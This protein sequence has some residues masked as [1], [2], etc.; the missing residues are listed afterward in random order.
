VATEHPG[1]HTKA[2]RSDWDRDERD[3]LAGLEAQVD[4][5]HRRHGGS[6]PLEMLRAA[7]A[8]LLPSRLQTKLSQHLAESAVSRTLADGLGPDEPNLGAEERDRLLGRILAEARQAGARRRWVWPGSLLVVSAA[9][10]AASIAWL[11][12]DPARWEEPN[13]AP[14]AVARAQPPS[15]PPFL[16]SFDKPDV[17][18]DIASLTWRGASNG[19]LLTDLKPGLDAYRRGDYGTAERALTP[20]AAHHPES[21]E[22]FFYQGVSRLF[23]DDLPGA[24]EA[25]TTADAIADSGFASEVSWYLAVAEQRAGRTGEA[26]AR[27]EGLCTRS[28]TDAARACAAIEA[29]TTAATPP[30]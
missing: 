27:L 5:M 28:G 10:A 4:A 6:P 19:Q 1:T 22:V 9:A 20:L 8:G 17:R 30:R 18:I 25:L 23:L 3:S 12:P 2:S 7:R 26:R 24:I 21:V 14:A 11:V 29:L 15:P 16:L 13:A